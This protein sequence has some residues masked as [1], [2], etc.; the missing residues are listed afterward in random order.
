MVK[1][2]YIKQSI[3]EEFGDC[4]AFYERKQRNL[5]DIVYDNEAVRL[6]VEAAL[7]S[8]GINEASQ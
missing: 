5:R 7:L 8:L 2:S 1:A 4:I 3:K 6:Y